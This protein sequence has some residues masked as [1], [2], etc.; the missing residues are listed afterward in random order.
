LLVPAQNEL[1]VLGESLPRGR[2]RE[3]EADPAGDQRQ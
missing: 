3:L 1:L 2:A